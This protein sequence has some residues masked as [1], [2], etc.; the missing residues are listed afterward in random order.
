[1]EISF[2][3]GD[4][5]NVCP[6]SFPHSFPASKMKKDMNLNII[7][8][9]LSEVKPHHLEEHGQV[10]STSM[11]LMN[12][13]SLDLERLIMQPNGL[14]TASPTG[15]HCLYSKM[16]N[17]EQEFTDG[18]VLS[19]E[20]PHKQNQRH[21][22]M[23]RSCVSTGANVHPAEASLY[24]SLNSYVNESVGTTINYNR[25]HDTYLPLPTNM[26]QPYAHP[27][28]VV[29][30]E[31]QIVPELTSFGDSPP[32]S[33]INLENQERIKAERKKLRNRIA[34]SKCRKRKLERISRLEEKVKNL[35]IKNTDLASTASVLR[36]QVAQLKQK[37]MNHVNSGCQLLPYHVQAY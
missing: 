32:L 13:A 10:A 36:E 5:L 17:V 12:L 1:M 26:E 34:A 29:K 14:A 9:V 24:V 28:Q 4:V 30:D 2:Y 18:F 33:P 37:V 19:L 15:S 27:T 23:N 16:L 3:H 7:D 31:P 35:K 20:D 21:N 25:D 8:E 11:G 22:I 6:V